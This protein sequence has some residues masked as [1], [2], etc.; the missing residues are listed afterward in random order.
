MKLLVVEDDRMVAALLQQALQEEGHSVDFASTG[1]EGRVRAL[2]QEYDGIVLDVGLPDS[3][4]LEIVRALRQAGRATPVLLLTGNSAPEDVA[5]GLD[6]GAD[7]YLTKPFEIVVLKARVRALLRRG[8]AMRNSTFPLGGI[9]LDRRRHEASV[10]A[11]RLRLTPKEFSL[12]EYLLTHP[13]QVVT[14]SELLEAVWNMHFDPGSNVVDVHVA[15]LRSKLRH[16]HARPQLV[17]VR[18]SGFMITLQSDDASDVD[19][20]R[21]P[22]F[23]ATV[24]Q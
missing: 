20:D 22:G 1:A 14:R 6:G 19:G 5:R 2:A 17:T 13:E 9:T 23:P 7:D 11:G 4:G 16:S 10:E 15:R 8:G 12:L 24:V 3:S 21:G 18:G